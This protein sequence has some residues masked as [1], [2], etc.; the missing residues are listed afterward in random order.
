MSPC[1]AIASLRQ[2]DPLELELLVLV[3]AERLAYGGEPSSEVEMHLLGREARC[4]PEAPEVAPLV[5]PL[6]GLLLQLAT[7]GAVGVLDRAVGGDVQRAGRDLEEG[8]AGRRPE[9]AHEQDALLLVERDDG[10]CAGVAADVALGARPV[11]R[12]IMSTRKR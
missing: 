6:S 10:D 5:G 11:G 4:R 3:L 1:S 12:S 8:P 7:G 2:R 9:L